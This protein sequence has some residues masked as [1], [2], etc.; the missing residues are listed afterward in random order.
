MTVSHDAYSEMAAEARGPGNPQT[1]SWT[2]TPSGTPK[3]VLLWVTA[4]TGQVTVTDNAITGATYGGVAMT[5]VAE[6]HLSGASEPGSAWLF[7]LLSGIPTGAQTVAFTAQAF[8][9]S[10]SA[11]YPWLYGQCVT[12]ASGGGALA[13][14]DSDTISGNSVT[15]PSVTM[16]AGSETGLSYLGGYSGKSNEADLAAAASCTDTGGYDF[17]AAAT[18]ARVVRQTTPAT[19]TFAIGWTGAADETAM[20]AATYYEVS[21]ATVVDPFG[22]SG[23]FGV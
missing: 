21:T 18:T 22:V 9:T 6:V 14:A 1:H 17:T 16:D 8:P 3:G 23:F 20:A 15:N 11:I 7:E 12:M 10:S 2:H 19:G 4:G 13:R 5:K